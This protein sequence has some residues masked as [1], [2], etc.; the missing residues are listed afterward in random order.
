MPP[1]LGQVVHG[2]DLGLGDLSNEDTRHAHPAPVDLQHDLGRG[3]R[4]FAKYLFEDRDDELHGRVIVVVQENLVAVRP[5]GPG[6]RLGREPSL[7]PTFRRIGT[8]RPPRLIAA[9]ARRV[10]DLE[11]LPRIAHRHFGSAPR[12]LR[13]VPAPAGARVPRVTTVALEEGIAD[14]PREEWN[15]LVG[16]DSPFLAWEWL[17]SLEEAGTLGSETG[18]L[19][20]PLTVRDE[21]KLVAA[22]PLYVKGHSEGEFVFDWSWADAA[23]RAGIAYYPKLLVGV[24]FTPVTGRRLLVAPG[25]DRE[26]LQASLADGLRRLCVANGMSGVHAN[27]CLPEEVDA[28]E[29]ETFL[30]RVGIQYHWKNRGYAS[31]E[32][33]LGDF[34]SKRRNQIRRERRELSREDVS[35]DVYAG[36]AI[37]D[38]CEPV[39]RFYLATIQNRYWGRQYLNRALFE[40]LW[41]RFR[42][43]MVLVVASHRGEPIAGTF[44]VAKNGVLYGRYWGA[45]HDI[46]FLHF[47]VCYY[48]AIEYCIENGFQR[49]EPGAGGDYKQLR[50]FDAQATYSA[51]FL[52]DPRLSQAVQRFLEAE[53]EQAENNIEWLTEHSALKT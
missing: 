39:Y 11:H 21:G 40:K 23:E 36:D 8:F 32:E 37:P 15:A 51:H 22:A 47:E 19:A 45:L 5:L 35:V 14:I 7:A 31:F 6:P 27:F 3:G 33:Y 43:R 38:L 13:A 17:A 10:H 12:S 18:W 46:R 1:L 48:R 9:S 44:N 26:A 30:R 28:L 41:E 4:A 20:H 2:R 52:A 49:F 29:G 50:G 34:R 24:P 42:H 53:R 16:E 25:A